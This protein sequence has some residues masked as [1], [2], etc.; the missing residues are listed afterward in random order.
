[1]FRKRPQAFQA[2]LLDGSMP[3]MNGPQTLGVLRDIRDDLPV[4]FM[5]GHS[6]TDLGKL[7]RDSART[8]RVRK[9]FGINELPKA[10]RSVIDA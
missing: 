10:L 6:A 8:A 2:A 5:S 1:M 3:T 9:P 4:V 7:D